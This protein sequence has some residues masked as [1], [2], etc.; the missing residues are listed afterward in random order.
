MRG[1]KVKKV[2]KKMTGTAEG[3]VMAPHG[4]NRRGP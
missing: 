2:E 1:K 3:A 4:R